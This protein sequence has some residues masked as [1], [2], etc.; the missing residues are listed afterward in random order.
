MG[1]FFQFVLL[2]GARFGF[3][4]VR[5]FRPRHDVDA[6][7]GRIMMIG[8]GN[9]AQMIPA[10]DDFGGGG[11]RPGGVHQRDLLL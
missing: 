9:A 6:S 7:A 10:G 5:I 2:I 1:A 11:A 4:F 3:R 8:A